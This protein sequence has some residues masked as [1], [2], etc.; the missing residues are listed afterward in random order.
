MIIYKKL[1]PIQAITFDLDDTLYENTSVIL[2]AERAL[3]EM[4]HKDFPDTQQVDKG[5]WRRQQRNLLKSD[6]NLKNDMSQLRYKSLESGFK[7]LGFKGPQLTKAT[8]QC[9][10]CFY[11]ERSNFKLNENIYSLIKYLANRLPLVAITNGNVDLHQIGLNNYFSA[12]FKANVDMPMKPHPAMF[13]EA[14]AYLNIPSQHILHVG[15]N[16]IKDIYG[17]L[18]AGFQTA[19]YADDRLMNLKNE[20]TKVLPHIQLKTLHQLT[21]LIF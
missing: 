12:C 17:A 7:Q 18:C 11:S 20:K 8:K 2:N 9:F 1:Q 13:S 19:W 16:L 4:M 14:K 15:D 5:F 6:P 10:D 3:L 21:E